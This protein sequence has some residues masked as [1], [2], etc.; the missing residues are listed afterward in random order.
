VVVS[1]DYTREQQTIGATE[2]RKEIECVVDVLLTGERG[3]RG[4]RA[5]TTTTSSNSSSSS[6]SSSGGGVIRLY[7][8]AAGCWS[9]RA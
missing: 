8:R 3:V 1:I 2:P 9:R 6:S 4:I 7:A 5:H